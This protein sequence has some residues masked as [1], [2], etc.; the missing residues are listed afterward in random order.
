MNKLWIVIIVAWLSIIYMLLTTGSQFSGDLT[1]ETNDY[2]LEHSLNKL[3]ESVELQQLAEIK[4]LDMARRDYFEH[5]DPD[6][7]NAWDSL[8]DY[9]HAGENL[10]RGYRNAEDTVTAWS[11]SETHN[12]NLLFPGYKQVGHSVCWGGE[13]FL[14]VQLFKG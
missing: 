13:K 10:A 7:N 1:A 12:A 9:Q 14:I 11:Q 6:G 3:E 5:L 4:C 2:R 8:V